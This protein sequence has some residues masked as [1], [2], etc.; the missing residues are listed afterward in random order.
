MKPLPNCKDEN[1]HLLLSSGQLLIQESIQ[2]RGLSQGPIGLLISFRTWRGRGGRGQGHELW[3]CRGIPTGS[4]AAVVVLQII[5]Q[6]TDPLDI[7][8]VRLTK[9]TNLGYSFRLSFA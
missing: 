4:I 5:H 7:S 8:G 6:P 1:T 3:A 2:G 9:V